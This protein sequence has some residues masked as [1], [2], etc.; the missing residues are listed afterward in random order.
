MVAPSEIVAR[1]VDLSRLLDGIDGGLVVL[2]DFQRDFDWST[3]NI[4]SLLATVLL[5]WPAGSLLLMRGTPTFFAVREFE[6][7]PRRGSAVDYVVLDGQQRL[8][9]L[10]QAFRGAGEMIYTLN[11]DVAEEA[12]ESAERLEEAI[13]PL[14]RGA[15]E[16]VT[17]EE[18]REQ[19][20][21]PLNA[22]RSASDFFSWR[23]DL[24]ASTPRP[25][26]SMTADRLSRAYKN[27]L[28]TVNHYEFPAV[29]LEHDLPPEAVAR[30][31]ERINRS[32][33][34]LGT[35]DLLVARTYTQDW[36][37]RLKW[38]EAKR[39]TDHLESFLG[40]DGLPV[41]QTIALRDKN[42]IRQP[43]LLSL[44]RARIHDEWAGA[45][46]RTDKALAFV[47]QL[48]VHNP[49]WLP[50]WQLILPLASLAAD[51]ELDDHTDVLNSWFWGR[52][53]SVEYETASSTKVASDY[54]LL[55]R[56]L[57]DAAVLETMRV[58]RETLRTSTRKQQAALWRTFLSLMT[59]RGVRDLLTG[60]VLIADQPGSDVVVVSLF[61]V[62]Q[63][64]GGSAPHLRILSQVIVTKETARRLRQSSLLALAA[65]GGLPD[66][67]DEILASQ[68]LPGRS[69]LLRAGD[70][71]QLI[72]LRLEAVERYVRE[73]LGPTIV[74]E[75]V[76]DQG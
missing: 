22:L 15:W 72:D 50:Y 40:D 17:I 57:R 14:R 10:Y 24:V 27:T 63:A 18:Q 4:V 35:F 16:R 23:D 21:V 51:S 19:G 45:I 41:L 73:E 7:A 30:I 58:S 54:R 64:A 44:D 76:T 62:P 5:G 8:T 38:E 69:Q 34:R 75:E 68:F 2:P 55:T 25:E 11:L 47:Q 26:R 43:A 49:N 9:A 37:L 1:P 29:I 42:D 13:R 59:K 70:P 31:F 53:L 71:Q 56:V 74:F 67:A 32:G 48:G 66:P 33:M 52:S 39:E 61:P 6:D 46:E 12:G 36:N 28:G 60:D 3:A 20:I 65:E